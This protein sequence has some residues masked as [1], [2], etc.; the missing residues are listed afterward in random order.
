MACILLFFTGHPACHLLSFLVGGLFLKASWGL[1]MP[2]RLLVV[3]TQ[4][5]LSFPQ[6]FHETGFMVDQ[7]SVGNKIPA[8]GATMQSY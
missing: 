3:V 5:L 1:M 4:H 6:L 8:R 2:S 7:S